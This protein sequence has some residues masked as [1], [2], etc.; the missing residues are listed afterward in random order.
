MSIISSNIIQCI[1]SVMIISLVTWISTISVESHAGRTTPGSE[2]HHLTLLL[3]EMVVLL[4][5]GGWTDGF[6]R[7]VKPQ[8]VE[9]NNGQ[10]IQS[11][12]FYPIVG[13]HLS[14]KRVKWIPK[15]SPRIAQRWAFLG[16]QVKSICKKHDNRWT[17]KYSTYSKIRWFW[18]F[19]LF[20]ILN[21]TWQDLDISASWGGL[22]TK[23][24]G[25]LWRPYL[26]LWNLSTMFRRL[27]ILTLVSVNF[28][29]F[30]V[31]W[32]FVFRFFL[33]FVGMLYEIDRCIESISKGTGSRWKKSRISWA[34]SF[35]PIN[36][37]VSCR[38]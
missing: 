12:L 31:N 22:T 10:V 32:R 29:P 34:W 1:W 16:M 28:Q 17:S 13:G 23:K 38:S 8:G 36:S 15:R 24:T 25:G 18:G 14:F 35:I 20:L 27:K 33:Q 5:R 4:F 2:A 19:K 21:P 37:R 26:W 3:V 6:H 9:K 7:L 30:F 11:D